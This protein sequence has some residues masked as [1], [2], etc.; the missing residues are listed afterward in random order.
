MKIAI[1]DFGT[2]FSSLSQLQQLPIDEIKVDQS[3]V[4]GMIDNPQDAVIVRSIIDLGH[5]LGLEIVAEGA[6]DEVQLAAL[7]SLGADRAQGYVISRPLPPDEFIPWLERM[8]R[9]EGTSGSSTVPGAGRFARTEEEPRSS[10][11]PE[12]GGVTEDPGRDETGP[13]WTASPIR[14]PRKPL[15][16]PP[17]RLVSDA[18]S[19]LPGAGHFR[20][21]SSVVSTAERP[22]PLVGV[23][24]GPTAPPE[25]PAGT[26]DSTNRQNRRGLAAKAAARNPV[27]SA[28]IGPEF[29]VHPASSAPPGESAPTL[30]AD[31]RP[32]LDDDGFP[33]EWKA[34]LR[35]PKDSGW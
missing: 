21:S 17:P 28:P 31:E 12:I 1:D 2:G 22:A 30:A 14:S 27:A 33:A 16:L 3:F 4:S 7:R 23:P 26:E 18:V 11:A 29:P 13:A 8:E 6:E 25:P 20:G 19:P 32:Q 34:M 10:A 9:G 15:E 24:S 5:N 35:R